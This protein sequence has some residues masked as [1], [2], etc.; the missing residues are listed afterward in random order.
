[1]SSRLQGQALFLSYF[2]T[3]SIGAAPG[4]VPTTFRSTVKRYWAIPAAIKC[5]IP[6]Q[7]GWYEKNP[8]KI[9]WEINGKT[10]LDI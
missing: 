6:R 2:K 10:L 3:L 4:I 7:S 5:E 1:M 8:V 9:L